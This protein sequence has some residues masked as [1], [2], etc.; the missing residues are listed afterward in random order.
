MKLS[1]IRVADVRHT[2]T[3]EL[4]RRYVGVVLGGDLRDP[5]DRIVEAQPHQAVALDDVDGRRWLRGGTG[6]PSGADGTRTQRPSAPNVQP[7]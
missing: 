6:T 1:V 4:I 2:S 7:W 5:G 3:P